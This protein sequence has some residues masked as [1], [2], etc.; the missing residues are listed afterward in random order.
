METYQSTNNVKR[1]LQLLLQAQLGRLPDGPLVQ[2]AVEVRIHQFH[3]SENR[4]WME[5]A[6]HHTND[7]VMR[8]MGKDLKFNLRKENQGV[9]VPRRSSYAKQEKDTDTN[10]TCIDSMSP[11]SSSLATVGIKICERIRSDLY[12]SNTITPT[13]LNSHFRASE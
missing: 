11:G 6:S 4:G 7:I 13:H 5:V 8:Q 2:V 3:H 12:P 9:F 10:S 1:Q